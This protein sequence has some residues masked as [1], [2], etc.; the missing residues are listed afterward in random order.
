MKKLN[1]IHVFL[2]SIFPVLSLYD[3]NKYILE[4]SVIFPPFLFLLT[5]AAVLFFLFNAIIKNR[6]KAAVVTSFFIC[7]FFSFGHVSA[8]VPFRFVT[9]GDFDITTYDSLLLLWLAIMAA[10]L[11]YTIKTVKTFYA[12]TGFLNIFSLIAVLIP[13]I[14]IGFYEYKTRVYSENI[15]MESSI[16]RK[17]RSGTLPDIYYIVLDAYARKDVLRNIYQYD[18]SNF[19]NYLSNRGFYVAHNSSANYPQTYLSMASA[20]NFEYINYLSEVMGE[21]SNDRKPLVHL[22]NKSKLYKFL[23]DNGY[24]FVSLAGTWAGQ[25]LETDIFMKRKTVYLDSFCNVLIDTSLLS[26]LLN[27]KFRLDSYRNDLL[28]IFDRIP[29]IAAI[30][31]PTFVY[32]HIPIPHPPF[33]FDS[34]GRPINEGIGVD[35]SHYFKINPGQDKYR[36]KYINQ[37]VFT[38]SIV[39]E[40][41]NN[42]LA[43]SNSSPIIILQSDHGPGSMTDWD[44]PEKTDVKERLSILNAYYVPEKAK[45]KLYNSITPVNS[46]RV[47]LKCIFNADI[48]LLED[49]SYFS[50]WNNPYKF[51]DVTEEI[52]SN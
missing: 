23:K 36:E 50:T 39:K 1:I 33:V 49:R 9:I 29:D 6:N 17:D 13:L 48:E 20:L 24:T 22:I 19:I 32:A 42:I 5:C 52:K 41:I 37:M 11:F 51:F 40:M 18:N 35:G 45:Q 47:L 4:I 46:F 28:Y 38:N 34:N 7:S 12:L 27:T 44:A 43:K 31:Q 14:S 10:L 3:H 21:E 2:F 26:V 8:W 15:Q 25:D 30:K 16:I